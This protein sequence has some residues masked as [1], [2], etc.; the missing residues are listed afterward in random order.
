ADRARA[1]GNRSAGA[2]DRA[3]AAGNRAAGTAD[4]ATDADGSGSRGGSTGCVP[5]RIIAAR[6]R[7]AL[8][9][10]A[11]AREPAGLKKERALEERGRTYRT[12]ASELAHGVTSQRWGSRLEP[13]R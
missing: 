13:T 6:G 7:T 3:R 12:Q 8:L 1:A 10:G 11:V 5:R 4:R 2:A 9:I